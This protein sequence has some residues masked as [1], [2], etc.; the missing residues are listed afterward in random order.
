VKFWDPIALSAAAGALAIAAFC[1]AMIPALRA[2]GL[3]P[4]KALRT[5]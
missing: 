3:S 1:A 5:E 4:I 2:A